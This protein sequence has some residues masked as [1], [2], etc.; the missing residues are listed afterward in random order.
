M[1]KLF[2]QA[3]V[4]AKANPVRFFSVVLALIVLGAIGFTLG[5]PLGWEVYQFTH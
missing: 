3:L 4:A 5:E 1:K 2:E